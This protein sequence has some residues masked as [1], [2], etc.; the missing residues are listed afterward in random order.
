MPHKRMGDKKIPKQIRS[1]KAET[2][3][4][5]KYLI[6]PYKVKGIYAEF[7]KFDIQDYLWK[8]LTFIVKLSTHWV[9]FSIL[10]NFSCH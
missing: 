4:N 10:D 6:T 3:D 1:P 5:G 2:T 9:V 7:S 8:V